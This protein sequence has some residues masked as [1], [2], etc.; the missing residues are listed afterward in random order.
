MVKPRINHCIAA[1]LV[2]LLW[3]ASPLAAASNEQDTFNS[4]RAAYKARDERALALYSERLK[5]Q[6][7]VL[8]PYLDSWRLLLRLE[9]AEPDEV[10]AFLSSYADYPFAERI[11][12]EWLKVLGKQ[13]AWPLFFAEHS[14]LEKED[15][16][17]SCYAA[18]GRFA[19]GDVNALQEGNELWLVDVDQPSTCDGLFRV[20]RDNGVLVEEDVWARM[21]LALQ[22][23]RVS[24]ARAVSR[25][26]ADPPDAAWLKMFDRV[27]ENPQ[28]SL[29][30]GVLT[31]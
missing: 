2:A 12:S 20:M 23:N 27:Y 22:A 4:A 5:A 18:L 21:R 26:L 17:V 1:I 29:E 31:T 9:K 30:K 8:A 7:Y 14:K 25:Y 11:R 24:V 16:A 15:A 10:R 28:R 3:L 6:K 13:Q 19:Q